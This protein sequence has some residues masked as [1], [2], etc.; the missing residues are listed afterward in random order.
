MG[1]NQRKGS[2][3]NRK[4]GTVGQHRQAGKMLHPLPAG[5]GRLTTSSW[6]NTRLP[7][8]IFLALLVTRLDRPLGLAILRKVAHSFQGKFRSGQDL[9]L[10]L[11][12]VASMPADLAGGLSIPFVR[13]PE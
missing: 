9:D 2:K 8:Q 4:H 3:E 1:N 7:Y 6:V 12:G 5:L 11:T 13:P 10:T